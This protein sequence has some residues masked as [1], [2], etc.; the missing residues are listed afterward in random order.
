MK[1]KCRTEFYHVEKL[2]PVDFYSYMLK[3]SGD[4]IVDLSTAK[5]WVVHFSS[6]NSDLKDKTH[7]RLPCT[8]GTPQN[9]ET[10]IS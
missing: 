1:Q 3:V 7:S 4:Q 6:D 2:V 8:A 9:D 5:R 10:S